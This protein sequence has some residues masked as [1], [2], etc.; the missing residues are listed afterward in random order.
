ML[1]DVSEMRAGANHSYSASTM[2]SEGVAAL[3]RKTVAA[4]IFGGFDVADAFG[5]ALHSALGQ[6]LKQLRNHERRLGTFGDNAHVA[7]S[8]FVEMDKRNSEALRAV[9]WSTTQT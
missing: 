6:H 1:V 3:S 7:A 4:G 2:A 5:A 9:L 8:T